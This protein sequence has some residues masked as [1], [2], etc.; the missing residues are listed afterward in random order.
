[1]NWTPKFQL[2]PARAAFIPPSKFKRIG[3]RPQRVY[4]YEMGC[5][6]NACV[7]CDDLDF[8]S[9]SERRGE[10][11]AVLLASSA[12]SGALLEEPAALAGC[13]RT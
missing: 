5:E 6:C 4:K 10:E 11:S 7:V 2:L 8:D 12:S 1:M 3:L 9:C 13:S